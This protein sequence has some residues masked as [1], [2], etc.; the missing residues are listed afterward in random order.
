MYAKKMKSHTQKKENEIT[1][2]KK[3]LH[4]HVDCTVNDKKGMETA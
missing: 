1:L 2:S 3:Y 4:S